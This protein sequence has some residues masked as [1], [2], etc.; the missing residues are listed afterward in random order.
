D[1]ASVSD[2][3]ASAPAADRM[4]LALPESDREFLWDLEHHGNV[5][6]KFGFRR[7][8]EALAG[9]NSQTLAEICAPEFTAHLFA[10]AREARIEGWSF[11]VER[12]ERAG[13]ADRI[14]TAEEFVEWLLAA[15]RPFSP[16]PK[17]DFGISSL[18]P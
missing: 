12:R 13:D 4:A 8:W 6:N 11:S 5:L 14:L 3:K 7:L 16:A 9:Q 15:R 1:L 17:F 10:D 2:P 18:S